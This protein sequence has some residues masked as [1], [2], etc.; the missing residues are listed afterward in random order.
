VAR[1]GLNTQE[2]ERDLITRVAWLYYKGKLTQAEIGD[3]V[4][5]SRQKVQRLL[6]KARDL[7]VI[8]FTLKHPQ[9][10]LLGIEQEMVR[11]FD[12]QDAVVVPSYSS[13]SE[14]MRRAYAQAGAPYLERLLSEVKNCVLG[15]GWGN[16]TAYFAEYFEPER[17]HG[18]VKIVSLI[19]N[20]MTNV[21]MNPYIAAERIAE[22]LNA[23][24]YNIWAP[25]IAHN[26]QRAEVFRSEPWIEETLKLAADSDVMLVSI[27]E[28]SQ[29]ASLFK[30]G[31]LTHDDLLRLMKEGAVGDILSR[32]FNA[33]GEIVQDEVHDRVIGIPIEV[34]QKKNKTVVGVAGGASKIEAIRA[35]L[36]RKYVNVLVTDEWSAG[37][38]IKAR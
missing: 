21:S 28:V 6:E 22:K 35:A 26:K 5:L 4:S 36:N 16:T 25:A 13:G 34:L 17:E 29:K 12:L 15:M 1:N 3:K 9:A 31:Y 37:E 32:F 33:E 23:P 10:N 19:G 8:R 11:R 20:L 38:L 27:G 18:K 2:A 7:E 30:M 14:Q 24:F